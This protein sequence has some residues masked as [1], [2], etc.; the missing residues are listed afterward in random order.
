MALSKRTRPKHNGGLRDRNELGSHDEIY[1][2]K[3]P[4]TSM[5]RN[6]EVDSSMIGNTVQVEEYHEGT[7]YGKG[8]WRLTTG[9]SPNDI[10]IIQSYHNSLQ[11]KLVVNCHVLL[12]QLGYD[13]SNAG[14]L[15]NRAWDLGLKPIDL[16]GRA[17]VVDEPILIRKD[18]YFKG[19]GN[20]QTGFSAA[21]NFIGNVFDTNNFDT[22]QSNQYISESDGVPTGFNLTGFYI[23][24]NKENYGAPV[25]SM[26]GMGMRV[27]GKQYIISDIR[28]HDTAGIGFYS[29][30][31]VSGSI[32][33]FNPFSDAKP[34]YIRD[35]FIYNT[36]YEGMVFKGATDILLDQIFIGWPAGSLQ[37]TTF[38][39]S[40]RSLLYP[41]RTI[42]GLVMERGA[43]LGFIHIFDNVH[44]WGFYAAN[45]PSFVSRITAKYLMSERCFGN[46]FFGQNVRFQLAQVMCEENIG[47]DGTRPHIRDESDRGGE[48]KNTTIFRG[49]QENGSSCLEVAG[50]NA[51]WKGKII[52]NVVRSGHGVDLIGS[53]NEVDFKTENGIGITNSGEQSSGLI[54]RNGALN[55]KVMFKARNCTN[56]YNFEETNPAS[57]FEL[58]SSFPATNAFSGVTTL[59][60]DQYYSNSLSNYTGAGNPINRNKGKFNA[61]I[62]FSDG[63]VQVL[64]ISHT[65]LRTPNRQDVNISMSLSTG[66]APAISRLFVTRTSNTEIDVL[67]EIEGSST[68]T[69][70]VAISI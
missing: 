39:P 13:G 27:Y 64:T 42:D 21:D 40:K 57:M 60:P 45:D 23:L 50:S 48:S 44:G 55:N 35:L 66:T 14:S 8:T 22:L 25:S 18:C 16:Y 2:R 53:N 15:L 65:L 63:A 56:N 26:T 19:L 52:S 38:N 68:A 54:W 59:V 7:G 70:N 67:V 37:E 6:L 46:L 9:Q 49:G 61:P 17:Y 12:E 31:S 10:D 29:E 30:L 62:D 33:N 1:T 41:S 69:G 51:T 58:I 5:L 24:G 28:I 34:G 11:W 47:G 36:D 3:I 43:E 32:A 4:N 20:K